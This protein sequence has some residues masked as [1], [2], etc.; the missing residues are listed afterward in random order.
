M[1]PSLHQATLLLMLLVGSQPCLTGATGWNTREALHHAAQ[2]AAATDEEAAAVAFLIQHMPPRDLDEAELTAAFL[3]AQT[4]L[5]LE[6]RAASPWARRVPWEL[7]LNDVLPYAVLGEARDGDWRS[8]MWP[9]FRPLVAA[10]GSLTEAAQALNR[11]VWATWEPPLRFVADQTPAIM[12]PFQVIAHGYASCTGMSTLLVDALRSQGIPARAAGTPRWNNPAGGNHVWVEVW[13]AGVWSFTGAAEYN[14][15]LNDTW[16][17]PAPAK[18]ALPGSQSCN[19]SSIFA[20]SWSPTTHGQFW[21]LYYLT[22]ATTGECL[23]NGAYIPAHDVT[24]SY[25]D[26]AVVSSGLGSSAVEASASVL[27][28]V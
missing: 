12:S 14:G 8:M 28:T 3:L 11:G 5:A 13:D 27:A 16:F 4:R 19:G 18:S 6:A 26:A 24:Q 7:F 9:R 15:R 2:R 17:F 23:P 21:P 1:T 25:L 20:S 22:N 10:A